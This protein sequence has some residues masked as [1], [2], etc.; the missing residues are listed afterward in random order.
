M[1]KALHLLIFLACASLFGCAGNSSNTIPANAEISET[2]PELSS[3]VSD[4]YLIG[5]GDQIQINVWKN[6]ELSLGVPV[7]PDG[8]VSMPLIGDVMAAGLSA[9]DLTTSITEKL[10][11]YLKQPIVS[12]IVSN[13][14]SVEYQRRVRITG[15]I[16]KPISMPYRDGMTVLDL[17]LIAGSVTDYADSKET[18]LHRNV[19]GQLTIFSINLED[20]LNKGDLTTNYILLPSDIVTVPEKSFFGGS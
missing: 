6:P 9:E 4:T 18:K 16:N 13:P 19:N 7:R 10:K 3:S 20:I 11:E 17:V 1:N 14:F 5:V 2:S 15:A 8:R 12:I